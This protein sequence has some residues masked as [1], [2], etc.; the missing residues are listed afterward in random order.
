MGLPDGEDDFDFIKRF[1]KLKAEFEE[2]L[3]EKARLNDL[4]AENLKKVK[5]VLVRDLGKV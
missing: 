5:L 4:T 1:T 3:K 2:Q